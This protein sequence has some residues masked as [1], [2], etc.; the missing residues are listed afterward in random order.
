MI[1]LDKIKKQMTIKYCLE[2]A[3]TIACM[4]KRA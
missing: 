2:E 4:K 1:A 3:K